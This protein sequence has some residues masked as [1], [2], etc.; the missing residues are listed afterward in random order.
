ME[1][2][3]PFIKISQK[4]EVFYITKMDIKFLRETVNFHF[5]EPYRNEE[6]EENKID[7]YIDSL[8]SM[9][10]NTERKIDGIQR[11]TQISRIKKIQEFV[12][13]SQDSLFPS[14]VILTCN[15]LTEEELEEAIVGEEIGNF[16]FPSN[17]IFTI[18]DGQHRL[19]GLLASNLKKFELP[20]TLFFNTSLS[21]STK[22]FSDINGNQKS[23]NKSLLYDLY[24]NMEGEYEEEKEY[25]EIV[26]EL[27]QNTS[28]PLYRQVKMLGTG[29]G[30]ISQ[31]FLIENSKKAFDKLDQRELSKQKKYEE[32]FKF[33]RSVQTTFPRD[34]PNVF[35]S[36]SKTNIELRT[37]V[38]VIS[39]TNGIGA[40]LL[41]FPKVFLLVRKNKTYKEV[42]GLVKSYDWSDAPK[43]SGKHAQKMIYEDLK[44]LMDENLS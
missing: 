10:I 41:L 13:Q 35:D 19:A 6:N 3:H 8:E 39:K 33:F 17:T 26:R 4:D 34:W 30:T 25:S 27:N 18:I 11:R 31:A 38:N 2:N 22:I 37:D 15:S 29:P 20:V 16:N 24:N 5:R 14:S 7:K 42:M 32:L 21:M 43:G 36:E 9:G 12:E 44:R 23:V 28:S 40:L 1:N